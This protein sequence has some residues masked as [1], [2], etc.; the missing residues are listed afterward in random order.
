M[1]LESS[2]LTA[3]STSS[4]GRLLLSGGPGCRG[5]RRWCQAAATARPG[6]IL[7]SVLLCIVCRIHDQR[8]RALHSFCGRRRFHDVGARHVQQAGGVPTMLS[9]Q[10]LCAGE[11][12]R[13]HHPSAREWREPASSSVGSTW[14]SSICVVCDSRVETRATRHETYTHVNDRGRCGVAVCH[15]VAPQSMAM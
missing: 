3:S 2:H 9:A 8:A 6:R 13:R 10:V 12:G 5:T 11:R 7:R 4:V 15:P 14:R 1:H